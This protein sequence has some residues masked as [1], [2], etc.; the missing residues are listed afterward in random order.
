MNKTN[1]VSAL[2]KFVAKWE[3][4]TNPNGLIHAVIEERAQVPGRREE[5]SVLDMVT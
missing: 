5:T 1:L 3:V 2:E 4:Q